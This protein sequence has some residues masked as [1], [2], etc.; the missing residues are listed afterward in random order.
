MRDRFRLMLITEAAGPPGPLLDRVR[1]AIR[2]GVTAVQVRRPGATARELSDLVRAILPDARAAGVPVLVNDRVDVA[3]STE[4]DGV[5][6]KRGSLP[7]QAVRRLVGDR[8]LI[9]ASTHEEWEVREAA[10]QGA[11]YVVFGPV[12]ETP[13]KAGLIEPRGPA[14]YA[15]AVAAAGI[16]VLALGGIDRDTLPALRDAPLRG[17]A[18]IRAILGADDPERA[19]RELLRLLSEFD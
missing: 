14:G 10:A 9:G 17:V 2:G 15:A 19:A 13:S 6:L 18:V 8:R 12:F 1:K 3:L 11:D 16:P 5:H 7:V 4:A